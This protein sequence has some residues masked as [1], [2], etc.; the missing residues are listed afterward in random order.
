MW[1]QYLVHGENNGR[2]ESY[3]FVTREEEAWEFNYHSTNMSSVLSLICWSKVTSYTTLF[4]YL[5]SILNNDFTF[6]LT[7]RTLRNPSGKIILTSVP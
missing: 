2:E 1:K 6:V 3:L 5:A 7:A 4:L